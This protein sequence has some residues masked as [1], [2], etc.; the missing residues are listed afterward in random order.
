MLVS[1]KPRQAGSLPK[2]VVL[3]QTLLETEDRCHGVMVLKWRRHNLDAIVMT[4]WCS[5]EDVTAV[6]QT[7]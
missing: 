7:S 1:K 5:N 2:I 6:T 3:I 4:S